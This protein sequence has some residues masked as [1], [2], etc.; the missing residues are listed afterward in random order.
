MRL[1][2]FKKFLDFLLGYK[3]SKLVKKMTTE[4]LIE[5]Y[6]TYSP[7][8]FSKDALMRD[9][10]KSSIVIYTVVEELKKRFP[11]NPKFKN[12]DYKSDLHL[13]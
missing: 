8:Y 6:Q 4:E 9:N 13:I 10:V 3:F 11:N 7:L 1:K 5:L 2:Q 12:Y